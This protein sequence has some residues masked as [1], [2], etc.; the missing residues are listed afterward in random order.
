MSSA[1]LPAS[2]RARRRAGSSSSAGRQTARF[3]TPR[4][5]SI[6][7]PR[8]PDPA[9]ARPCASSACEAARSRF[10]VPWSP[11]SS[12]NTAA[13]VHEPVSLPELAARGVQLTAHE[14]EVL[15]LSASHIRR[16]RSHG[17]RSQPRTVRTHVAS[18]VLKLGVAD[19]DAARR[20]IAHAAAFGTAPDATRGAKRT[21]AGARGPVQ[22]P[23][24]RQQ[25][26]RRM[27]ARR[28]ELLSAR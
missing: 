1:P 22:V 25:S 26:V 23:A 13:G 12:P 21:R 18:V 20:V 15:E 28:T 16:R 9:P 8:W 6:W 7:L 14:L 2:R 24:N 5:R 10:R 17:G 27:D 19:H 3:S 4:S 11:P